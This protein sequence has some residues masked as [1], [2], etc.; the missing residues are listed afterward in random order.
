M[1][2]T[3]RVISNMILVYAL[4][5]AIVAI[6][7]SIDFSKY[8]VDE[9]TKKLLYCDDNYEPPVKQQATVASADATQEFSNVN[10]DK[11][12]EEAEGLLCRIY[13]DNK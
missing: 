8:T 10:D 7:G 11:A 4:L 2:E 12:A 1:A 3:K 5:L 9:N 6:V 13:G